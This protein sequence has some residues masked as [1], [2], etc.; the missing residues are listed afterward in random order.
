MILKSLL[1]LIKGDEELNIYDVINNTYLHEDIFRE[2]CD[3]M[4]G[5]YKVISI[6]TSRT[7]MGTPIIEIEVANNKELSIG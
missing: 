1:K 6:M 7:G 4:Y 2:Q 5:S 3:D